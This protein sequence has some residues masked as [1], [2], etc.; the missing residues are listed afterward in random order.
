MSSPGRVMLFIGVNT[1]GSAINHLFPVWMELLGLEA[2]LEGVDVPIDAPPARFREVIDAVWRR[3]DV[4]GALITTHKI[5]ILRH[6]GD[7][8]AELDR[9]ARMLGEVSA[10][11]KLDGRLIGRAHV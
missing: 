10:I 2:C 9:Y 6:A 3:E 11:R 5:S 1:A 7:R 4:E 8:F